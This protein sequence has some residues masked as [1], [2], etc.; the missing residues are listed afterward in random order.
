MNI[1]MCKNFRSIEILG[2][3]TKRIAVMKTE[4]NNNTHTLTAT[5]HQTWEAFAGLLSSF[6][7]RQE[8]TVENMNNSSV[9]TGE[10]MK[11][12]YEACNT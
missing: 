5:L 7:R 3:L 2:W 6:W 8:M 9:G 10:E 1:I 12:M 4:G 11:A